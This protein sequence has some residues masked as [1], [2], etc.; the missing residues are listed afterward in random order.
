MRILKGD[1]PPLPPELLKPMRVRITSACVAAR[2][3]R[4][5][6]EEVVISV[7]DGLELIRM[8]LAERVI[9]GPR[10]VANL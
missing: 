7:M 8:G 2:K 3:P 5:V 4:A 1:N 6:G 9:D 10:L